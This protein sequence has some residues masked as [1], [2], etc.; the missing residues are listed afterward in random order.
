MKSCHQYQGLGIIIGKSGYG[1][2][3]TLKQYATA[4]RVAYIECDDTMGSHDFVEALEKA[5]GMEESYGS[6]CKRVKGVQAFCNTNHGYLI[7]IDEADKLISKHTQKKM[8]IIRGLFDRANVGIIIAGELVLE[9]QVKQHL[10]RMAN[11]IDFYVRLKGLNKNEV[12]EYLA[13]YE[14]EDAARHE[15]ERRAYGA[16]NACFRLFDRTMNNV[17]RLMNARGETRITMDII[18]DASVMMML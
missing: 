17:I 3:Y 6:I 13:A 7:I 1:K 16:Q 15:L 10:E 5:L 18:R 2:T 11:R 8:E 14:V 4:E 12:T 9:S